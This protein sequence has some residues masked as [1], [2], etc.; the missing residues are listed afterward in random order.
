MADASKHK[1]VTYES[2]D[3]TNLDSL[4]HALALNLPVV[5]GATLYPSFESDEVAATGMVPLPTAADLAAGPVGGHCQV[6]VG[7][8]TTTQLFKV[9]NSWGTAWGKA[10]YCYIPFAYLTNGGL[11]SDFWVLNSVT[12]AGL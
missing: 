3:N 1:A 6:I 8:N 9:R 5:F 2:V 10:G 4:L 7:Y 12:K 11:A